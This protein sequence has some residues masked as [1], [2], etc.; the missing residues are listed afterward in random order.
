MNG[1]AQQPSPT[2]RAVTT[3]GLKGG[4]TKTTLSINIAQQ[5]GER[6]HDVC[7]IDTDT[8]G[9]A[10][11]RLG[12]DELYFE[13][14][15]EWADVL[16][17]DGTAEPASIVHDTEFAFDII[18]ASTGLESLKSQLASE[19]RATLKLRDAVVDPLLGAT[20]DYFVIDTGS[21]RDILLNNAV[22][23]SFN[24]IIPLVPE[25][26]ASS[27]L[28]RTRT[29]IIDP[30]R[31]KPNVDLDVLAYVPN[32]LQQRF[33]QRND[34]RELV[35]RLCTTDGVSDKVPNF[36]YFSEAEFEQ[37]DA[38]DLHAN[39]GLRKDKAFDGS[40]PVA[41]SDPDNEQL[42]YLEELAAIVEQGGVQR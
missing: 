7:L 35:E 17:D 37:I 33:D 31:D 4:T 23:A 20:Y 8:N 30:L 39:P 6:G 14:E 36:A 28:N 19:M 15:T 32:K 29:R 27:V 9:H 5:L 41:V 34:E 21:D 22:A 38:G 16:L 2:P 25:G 24:L 12:F 1:M 26:G 18:P 42:P 10:T 40:A 13:P 3:T 11:H